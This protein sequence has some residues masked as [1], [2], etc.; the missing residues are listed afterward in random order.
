MEMTSAVLSFPG[1]YT[2]QSNRPPVTTFSNTHCTQTEYGQ[3]W[4][5]DRVC[6]W[7][8]YDTHRNALPRYPSRKALLPS[9]KGCGQQTASNSCFSRACLSSREQAHWSHTF[10]RVA[11]AKQI[12][13][14]RLYRKKDALQGNTYL[15]T[16]LQAGL[17]FVGLASQFNFFLCPISFAPSQ[18]S[19]SSKYL[20]LRSPFQH[21]FLKNP[22]RNN[23]LFLF[24][25]LIV[26]SFSPSSQIKMAKGL[27]D[28]KVLY[29][30]SL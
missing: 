1:S 9:C 19:I 7:H 8:H 22:T 12:G 23:H 5:R 3:N 11:Q 21:I 15:H 6:P 4:D 13:V 17:S 10:P 14:Q 27:I 29:Q 30:P 2:F 16:L 28:W 20:V 25:D 24:C 18:V 26:F